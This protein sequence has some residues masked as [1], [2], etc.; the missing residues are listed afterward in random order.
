[1]LEAIIEKLEE[2]IEMLEGI[3]DD[4]EQINRGFLRH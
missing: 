4:K 1:M 2:I 3:L